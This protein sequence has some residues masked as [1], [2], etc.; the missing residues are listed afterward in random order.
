MYDSSCS[1]RVIFSH[2]PTVPGE[3]SPQ[4]LVTFATLNLKYKVHLYFLY[5]KEKCGLMSYILEPSLY[6]KYF[7]LY[8]ITQIIC[9]FA[10]S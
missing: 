3:S 2:Q 8:T 6:I 4:K 5:K 1:V 7:H 9:I 10:L